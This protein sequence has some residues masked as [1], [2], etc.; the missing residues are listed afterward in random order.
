M[1]KPAVVSDQ[2]FEADVLKSD[3]P[4]LV[5]FWATWC[6]PCRMVAPILEEIANE[7]SD[8]IKVVKLDVDANP[9]TAGRFGVRSI[10]TMILFKNGRETQRLVGYMPKERLLQQLNPHL[11]TAAA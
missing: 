8:K 11:G 1:T 5:D 4:V 7:Q 10:P 2:T 3:T 6:G 9:V